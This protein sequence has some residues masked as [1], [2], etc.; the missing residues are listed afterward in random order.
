MKT[1][2]NRML[3]MA[4]WCVL[5]LLLAPW[6][7]KKSSEAQTP[8]TFVLTVSRGDGVSGSPASGTSSYGSGSVVDYDYALETGY[9]D[10][11]V[12]MDDQAVA[13]AGSITMDGDHTLQASAAKIAY[14]EGNWL[15]D[16]VWTSGNCDV[17]DINAYACTGTQE[18]GNFTLTLKDIPV[19]D[20]RMDLVLSGPID[21]SGNFT[22]S[23]DQ[24][25]TSDGTTYNFEFTGTGRMDGEDN[26]ESTVEVT[27]TLVELSVSCQHS[28]TMYGTRNS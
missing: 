20:A 1:E 17:E 6:G 3:R 8:A 14:M 26:F 23:G 15:I 27:I 9:K 22:L 24:T 12:L 18:N 11:Q 25:V 21:A 7:C 13:E 10:L 28:G 5:P 19:G 4:V 2:M 16:I